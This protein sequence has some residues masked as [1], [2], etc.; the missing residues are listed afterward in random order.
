MALALDEWNE[1]R[2][3]QDLASRSLINFDRE[4][5]QN[6]LRLEDV[7][8]FH[9]GLRDLLANMDASG[10]IVPATTIRN[11]LEGFQ[12]AILVSTAWETA[13]ATGALG[14]M[15]YDVVAGLSLTYNLQDRLVTLNR[16]G[17]NDL[18][19]G[20]LRSGETEPTL[21]EKTAMSTPKQH[22]RIIW[23]LNTCCCRVESLFRAAPPW[24]G[25]D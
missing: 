10:E 2:E 23:A 11:I 16:S 1:D 7:T 3:F 8:L 18:L 24:H 17:L 15:D 12:P 5:Q 19:V 20:G 4:I 22:P 9:V 14:Y 21:G 25:S 6:R 13:V